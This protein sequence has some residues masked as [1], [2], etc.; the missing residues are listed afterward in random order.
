[1]KK[2]VSVLLVVLVM[3]LSPLISPAA[4]ADLYEDYKFLML[5]LVM[6]GQSIL[7]DPSPVGLIKSSIETAISYIEW[8]KFMRDGLL[9]IDGSLKDWMNSLMRS[10]KNCLQSYFDFFS[11]ARTHAFNDIRDGKPASERQ[12]SLNHSKN[13]VV[14]SCSSTIEDIKRMRDDRSLAV[15]TWFAAYPG[16]KDTLNQMIDSLQWV[17]NNPPLYYQQYM[18]LREY[19]QNQPLRLEDISSSIYAD[20]ITANDATIRVQFN[21]H[22]TTTKFGCWFGSDL[23]NLRYVEETY[24][25]PHD[26]MY[27][28]AKKWFGGLQP[29]TTYYYRFF[30]DIGGRRYVSEF[31]SFRTP[32]GSTNARLEDIASNIYV[33][34]ITANDATI[35]VQF[36][37]HYTTTKFGCWFGSD[38]NNLRYVEETYPKPHDKMYYNAQKWFGGLQPGITYYYRFF[39]DIGGKHYV[40]D[41]RSFL[42]PGLA[43]GRME[44]IASSIYAEGI[45]QTDATIRV[46]FKQFYKTTK[47]GCWFGTDHRSMQ[48]FEES[49]PQPHDKMY[50]NAQKWFG[51]LQPG[52][53]YYYKFFADIGSTHYVSDTYSFTSL[54]T[55]SSTVTTT[56]NETRAIPFD[57]R[58]MPLDDMYEDEPDFVAREGSDGEITTFYEVTY[59]NGVETARK[60]LGE[61]ETISMIPRLVYYGTKKR[62]ANLPGDATGN[63]VVDMDDFMC[64]VD[65]LTHG[66]SCGSMENADVDGQNGVDLK[67][68]IW[69][70]RHIKGL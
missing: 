40:S 66:L 4:K 28:N 24:P 46:Q 27:Y 59:N 25:K 29:G 58:R 42:T 5:G 17:V 49:Y 44:D 62:P 21:Q 39:A 8:V 9:A 1:M 43:T 48:Y 69:I 57:T 65:Y 36:N 11:H 18:A 68:L 10:Y 38:L 70:L 63:G 64:V 52:T 13:Y 31:Y 41:L 55:G 20:G 37:Q 45:S 26:K 50:Y 22:Y 2:R 3:L 35:R 14:N 30:A 6:T 32:Q 12:N 7:S 60:K 54:P 15:R 61:T 19:Y 23:N 47:F 67:D 16:M 51:G 34:G 56:V 33:D 53:T